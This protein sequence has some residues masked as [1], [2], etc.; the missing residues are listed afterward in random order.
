LFPSP[1]SVGETVNVEFKDIFESELLVV[2]RDIKGREFYSKMVINI[3]GGKLI[4]V[5]IEAT[6]PTGVYL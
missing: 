1:V 4:G 6:I 5:P 3:E 2:L